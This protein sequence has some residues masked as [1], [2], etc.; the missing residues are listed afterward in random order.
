MPFNVYVLKLV[1]YSYY[2]MSQHDDALQLES[3]YLFSVCKGSACV[4]FST[5]EKA[6]QAVSL[7]SLDISLANLV[8]Y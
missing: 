5:P 4:A 6:S 7:H 3:L 1:E 8:S 2:R